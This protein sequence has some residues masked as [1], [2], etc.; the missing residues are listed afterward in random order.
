MTGKKHLVHL[1]T[2]KGEIA[3]L[4]KDLAQSPEFLDAMMEFQYGEGESDS[5]FEKMLQIAEKQA[6]EKTIK[7]SSIARVINNASAS[8]DEHGN[9]S[10]VYRVYKCF[11]EMQK[12]SSK[13]LGNY[14]E[15]LYLSSTYFKPDYELLVENAVQEANMAAAHIITLAGNPET[16]DQCFSRIVSPFYK[17]FRIP[18]E[19]PSKGI[20][21]TNLDLL[22]RLNIKSI[23]EL[24]KVLKN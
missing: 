12:K 18:K 23:S 20:D 17:P 8:P 15:S 14:S 13:F 7:I 24:E 2:P 9:L 6:L 16:V 1:R 21:I 11:E 10:W 4:S 5:G 22:S 3:Y 19:Y